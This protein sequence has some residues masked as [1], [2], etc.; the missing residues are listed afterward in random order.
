MTIEAEGRQGSEPRQPLGAG[1]G[2]ELDSPQ[3]FQKITQLVGTMFHPAETC[4]GLLP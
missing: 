4:A 3:S 2:G 1:E